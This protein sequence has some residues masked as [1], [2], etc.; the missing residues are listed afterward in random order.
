MEPTPALPKGGSLN[1]AQYIFSPL[2]DGICNPVVLSIG[3]CNAV[4]GFTP[5]PS[6]GLGWAPLCLSDNISLYSM[7]ADC[8]SA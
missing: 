5:L 6:G 7:Q 3:I 8:K 2:F 4:V 1:E